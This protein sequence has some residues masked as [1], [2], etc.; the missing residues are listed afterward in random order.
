MT[1]AIN[2]R[3]ARNR[4]RLTTEE[5]AK[6]VHLSVEE[7]ERIERGNFPPTPTIFLDIVTT[8]CVPADQLLIALEPPK[9]HI[10]RGSK[11]EDSPPSPKPSWFY[12]R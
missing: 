9:L 12:R 11:S 6:A 3:R 2:I 4:L 7:Y 1:L 5:V 10:V 8:L